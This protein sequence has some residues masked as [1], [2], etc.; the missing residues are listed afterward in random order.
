MNPPGGQI[1]RLRV[2]HVDV[3]ADR[4]M[5]GNGLTVVAADGPLTS[6][7]MLQIAQELRQ[8]ETIF[9]FDAADGNV[10]ARIFTPEEELHFAGHPVLGAAAVLHARS[11][12]EEGCRSLTIHLGDR[13]LRVTTT[14][15]G[16]GSP[17]EA[18]M[19]QGRATLL[20]PIPH[21]QAVRFAAALGLQPGH[22]RADLPSQ[23]VSTGLPYLLLALT[24]DGVANSHI[25][26]PD[27]P[28][29]LH[30]VGADFIYALDPDRPEG[31]TWDNRGVTEDIATG[32]AAGPVAAYL[33]HHGLRPIVEPFHVHQG[34]FV[35]RPSLINVRQTA[36]GS[37]WVA[38]HVTQF[39]SGAIDLSDPESTASA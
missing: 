13:A 32:S 10:T 20:S 28:A 30:N 29:M 24:A 38:G 25:A 33:V 36:D 3:F 12:H 5:T 21:E 2:D 26:A 1:R 35:S 8:F 4:P 34:R 16:P 22:L 15:G 14:W 9:L 27:L 19:N 37:V 31:R 7:T 6:N 17:I 23:V 39:S 18:E 11:G